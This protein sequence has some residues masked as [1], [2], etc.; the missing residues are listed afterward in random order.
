V[1]EKFKDEKDFLILSH[2][3]DPERDSVAAIKKIFR[4]PGSE[5]S[6]MDISHGKKRQLV[7]YSK[8]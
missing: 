8:E 7:Y 6:K 1:Y 5:Y 3:C 4:F 2:T